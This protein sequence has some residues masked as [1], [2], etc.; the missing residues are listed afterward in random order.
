MADALTTAKTAT[1]V[2][3]LLNKLLDPNKRRA[4]DA[5][6]TEHVLAEIPR[7]VQVLTERIAKLSAS[8]CTPEEASIIAYQVFEAQKRTLDGDKRRRLSN[9]LINGL[10]SPQWDRATH[11]LMLRFTDELEE[12]HIQRLR[13]EART[14]QE[15]WDASM[16]A[17][18][19]AD[20]DLEREM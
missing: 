15:R 10:C 14:K 2:I 1:T 20:E 6:I 17:R 7:V 13:W 5:A 8:G 9:V 18:L 3:G 12:E 11:R 4:L 19:R 16:S